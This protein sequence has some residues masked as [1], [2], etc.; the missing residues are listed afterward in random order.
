MAINFLLGLLD[1]QR[2]AISERQAWASAAL[3]GGN[4][5]GGRRTGLGASKSGRQ[6]SGRRLTGLSGGGLRKRIRRMRGAALGHTTLTDGEKM[7]IV[8]ASGALTLTSGA[9]SLCGCIYCG[10]HK[11]SRHMARMARLTRKQR[12]S[13]QDEMLHLRRANDAD[14]MQGDLRQMRLFD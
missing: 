1:R 10:R 9:F 2:K 13:R 14:Q 8:A 6:C 7:A 11:N 3:S 4:R 12:R 5:K